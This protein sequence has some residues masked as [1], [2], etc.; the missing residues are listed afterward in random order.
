M[1]GVSTKQGGNS[2]AFPDVCKTPTPGGPVPMPYPNTAML[3]QA[4]PAACARKV[5][6]LN[7]PV[8]TKQTDIP[9][10]T[11]DEAGS[12]GGVV[13]GSIKGPAKFKK[14]SMKVKVEGAPIA[15]QTCPMGHNGSNANAPAGIHATPSQ[16]KVLVSG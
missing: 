10:T 16:V 9:M 1:F 3:A 2:I 12:A 11:G 7:Q 5:K 15:F 6:V 13:S 4:N 8:L 14:G